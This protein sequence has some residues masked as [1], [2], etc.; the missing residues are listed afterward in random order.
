MSPA[1]GQRRQG[2]LRRLASR[3][4]YLHFVA[5]FSRGLLEAARCNP[6]SADCFSLP[7]LG[8]V[9]DL[10]QL[11]NPVRPRTEDGERASPPV[12]D[13][14]K[15]LNP[16][17]PALA[18]LGPPLSGKSALLQYIAWRLATD[19]GSFPKKLPVLVR[20]DSHWDAIAGAAPPSL[21]ELALEMLSLHDESRLSPDW[22]A[23]RLDEGECLILLDGLDDCPCAATRSKIAAWL[24][25]QFE[26]TPEGNRFV[27]AMR[28][29]AFRGVSLKSVLPAAI[30]PLELEA[31]APLLGRELEDA[32]A[33]VRSG[34]RA[35]AQDLLAR[36]AEASNLIEL[37]T[38]PGLL[39]TIA[40]EHIKRSIAKAKAPLLAA[41][42]TLLVS[43]RGREC[44]LDEEQTLHALETLAFRMMDVEAQ[45]ITS[46]MAGTIAERTL[47]A[48]GVDASPETFL[49][50][51]EQG[52][53]LLLQDA[54]GICR[55]AHRS[56][57]EYLAAAH[58]RRLE[59]QPVKLLKALAGRV[60]DRR[61]NESIR[62]FAEL[63]DADAVVSV[64]LVGA[65]IPKDRMILA[66]D[67]LDRAGRGVGEKTRERLDEA[68]SRQLKATDPHQ[69]RSAAQALLSLRLSR[70]IR[71]DDSRFIDQ[72]LIR[73]AEYQLFLDEERKRGVWRQP[74][75]WSSLRFTAGKGLDPALGVRPSD[76]EAFCKWLGRQQP[77]GW[78]IRFPDV[79]EEKQA[80]DS[81]S[82]AAWRKKGDQLSLPADGGDR[83]RPD[84][85][86]GGFAKAVEEDPV[87]GFDLAKAFGLRM[88]LAL[89]QDDGEAD[90]ALVEVRDVVQRLLKL[91]PNQEPREL[92]VEVEEVCSRLS[93]K[94]GAA[95]ANYL[96]QVLLIPLSTVPL[97]F[98][99][100]K[101]KRARMLEA[102]RKAARLMEREAIMGVMRARAQVEI[103]APP[104]GEE[105]LS[106]RLDRLSAGLHEDANAGLSKAVRLALDRD[107]SATL[108]SARRQVP[109]C[110]L[111]E[112]LGFL[113]GYVLFQSYA[114]SAVHLR[115]SRAASGVE[116]ENELGLCRRYARLHCDFALLENRRQG[117]TQAREGIRIVRQRAKSRPS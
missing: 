76:A 42:C 101:N 44:R 84:P 67:C 35:T 16:K 88:D 107:W 74:D 28:P 77:S 80:A 66:L 32:Q 83:V 92:I 117:R 11:A 51:V 103:E 63:G 96:R 70:M 8:P 111:S 109:G 9:K 19:V 23:Q 41:I 102:V 79:Q 56:L 14:L 59:S 82:Q 108:Q 104:A 87:R 27:V 25:R 90:A 54:Q 114:L 50:D 58:L 93:L 99:R 20:L 97:E 7:R 26:E 37:T 13:W 40:G 110:S 64:A 72:S 95:V 91:Q 45:E 18:L 55:F 89:E 78:I 21:E 100:Q 62:L 43:S 71:L 24:Q 30:L 73:N 3:S 49:R 29:A 94:A 31:V 38:N 22:L 106:E 81:S 17:K 85:S 69:R 57:H 33:Q 115:R 86:T 105:S 53:G 113:R 61:W 10:F 39:A 60:G 112:A 48:I 68:L 6:E 12:E 98:M 36:L 116:S 52:S 46:A 47:S 65:P 34:D 4:A 5:E 75:H 15:R 1:S 2:L